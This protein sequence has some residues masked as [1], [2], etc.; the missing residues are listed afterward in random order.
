MPRVSEAEKRKSHERIVKAA[1]RLFRERG[2][3]ATSVADVMQEAGLT[4]GGFYRHFESKDAM[5]AAAF[6]A[7][8]AGV[9]KDLEEA[10]T[11]DQKAR[12][13]ESYIHRYL[14]PDHATDT[15]GGCPVATMG[16]EIARMDG[17]ARQAGADAVS[18]MAEGLSDGDTGQGYALISLM[19]GSVLFAR[20]AGS[21]TEAADILSAGQRAADQLR[22]RSE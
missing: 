19:L 20:L 1:S 17:P 3:E 6:Q 18:R 8:L 10:Q 22:Q 5:V 14:S 15:A 13:I 21:D 16:A 11:G 7:A 12:A 9:L 2:V 4:H